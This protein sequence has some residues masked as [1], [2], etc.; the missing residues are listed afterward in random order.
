MQI[1]IDTLTRELAAGVGETLLSLN[2]DTERERWTMDNLLL[3]L[4]LKWEF[5]SYALIGGLPVGYAIAS[6]KEGAVHLHR[7]AVGENWRNKGVGQLL[8]CNVASKAQK[9]SLSLFTLKT[10]SS[11]SDVIE[12]YRRRGFEI[13]NMNTGKDNVIMM[14]A[15]IEDVISKCPQA[16][17]D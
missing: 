13:T 2:L 8:I 1:T 16:K 6:H 12:Y 11:M 15:R 9:A 17:G 4:P 14:T 7:I 5:S 10:Y 3:D